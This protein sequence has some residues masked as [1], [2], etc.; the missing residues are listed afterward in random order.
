[1]GGC[2]DAVEVIV[3]RFKSEDEILPLIVA[4][5]E[6]AK[7]RALRRGLGQQSEL[8]GRFLKHAVTENEVGQADDALGEIARYSCITEL[9]ADVP[10]VT[11]PSCGA[12]PRREAAAKSRKLRKI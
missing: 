10:A 6:P 12:Q 3:V 8:R 2:S 1:M 5:D 11:I 7:A 9:T 4:P